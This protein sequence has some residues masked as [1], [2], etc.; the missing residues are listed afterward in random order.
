M[1]ALLVFV[2]V[3]VCRPALRAC[4]ISWE[5]PRAPFAKEN[6]ADYRFVH[7]ESWGK[8]KVSDKL[9]IP[10]HV[11]FSPITDRQTSRTLGAGWT[12]SLLESI[13]VPVSK[14][15]Y[16]LILPDGAVE[17]LYLGP[18]NRLEGAGWLGQISGRTI[19]VQ[20]S[21]GTVLVFRDGRL[22]QVKA[23]GS[24]LDFSSTADG[25]HQI[26]VNGRALLR[27][28]REWDATST[29]KQHTLDF[30]GKHAVLKMG[31]RPLVIREKVSSGG[32]LVERERVMQTE[33]LVSVKFDGEPERRYDF[34][35]DGLTIGKEESRWD[36]QQRLVFH[37]GEKYEFV[38]VLG[39]SCIKTTKPDGQ[40][41]H[42]G[43]D[44]AKGISVAQ[45]PGGEFEITEEFPNGA[46]R[47]RPRRILSM[48]S[49]KGAQKLKR[50]YWYDENAKALRL[51]VN[52]NG[53]STL[54][55]KKPDGLVSAKNQMTGAVL[56][57][58]RR[59]SLGRLTSLKLGNEVYLF[60]YDET[61]KAE[62]SV[63]LTRVR[64]S[65]MTKVKLPQSEINPLL[66]QLENQTTN[67]IL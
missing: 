53:A 22:F 14:E 8:I 20:A 60:D 47:G 13:C 37:N 52:A 64:S 51:L 7:W 3:W 24:V 9:T 12:F 28:K 23:E 36:A 31:R 43:R 26:T 39:I 55:E 58:K 44:Y 18:N 56:W 63:T 6:S 16:K 40:V 4:G 62:K 48:P 11:G 17:P 61:S 15:K 34:K 33:S 35:P 30:S 67:V 65:G 46:L 49:P 45:F 10:V 32:K 50:Q 57:E 54:Y 66:K 5:L 42:F 19:T 1:F 29:L 2:S 59:D 41:S 38:K 21:C 27:L 25:T